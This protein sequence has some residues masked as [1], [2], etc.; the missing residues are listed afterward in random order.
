MT[1][2]KKSYLAEKLGITFLLHV[3]LKPPAQLAKYGISPSQAQAPPYPL[4]FGFQL[5]R[6]LSV[7]LAVSAQRRIA[8][9]ENIV[10]IDSFDKFRVLRSR[11][12]GLNGTLA[13][14]RFT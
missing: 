12:C 2:Q 7:F 13:F 8:L 14:L 5:P 4:Q 3:L 6:M 1:Q 10:L 11:R 9:S